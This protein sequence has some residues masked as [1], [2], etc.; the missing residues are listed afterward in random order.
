MTDTLSP[1]RPPGS[2]RAS[3]RQIRV[4]YVVP[5]RFRILAIGG[6]SENL[7]E[8]G[9]RG[10]HCVV[11]RQEARRATAFE[12]SV[13]SGLASVH[14]FMGRFFC[15]DPVGT[16]VAGIAGGQGWPLP[17]AADATAFDRRR[18]PDEVAL[19]IGSPVTFPPDDPHDAVLHGHTPRRVV[20][21]ENH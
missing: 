2:S 7:E 14:F 13:R 3:A 19:L 17:A 10:E 6:H 12:S 20:L 1:A 9:D 16:V 11:V 5:F 4:V 8:T 15:P 18:S 21:L